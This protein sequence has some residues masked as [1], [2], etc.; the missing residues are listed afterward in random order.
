MNKLENKVAIITGGAMGNGLGIAK[1]FLKYGASIIILDYAE[2]IKSTI[3][4]L[5]DE[6]PNSKISGFQVDIRNHKLV[7]ACVEAIMEKYGKIDILVNN[8]GV[9][10]LESF[11]TMT[12][13]LRDF[14]FDIN[15]K[16]TWNITK[17]VVPYMKKNN[18]SS[19]INLSSVTGPLVA[20]SG[21]VAYA[22]TK[23]ALLGFTKSLAM[24]LVDN[25]IRVNAIMPGYIMTP[26]VEGISRDSNPENPGSVVEGIA[27]GIPMKR[28]GSIEELGELAAF[29]ASSE[30]SYITGQ[31]IV[32]DGGSTLPET[33][34]VGV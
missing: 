27:R 18:S 7:Q 9:C 15:I 10:R 22:T 21:E 31:G 25:N 8:A 30:S 12:D 34:S 5:R 4:S 1:V 3:K 33:M 16:G 17:S 23:A 19:I 14:H 13:E 2:K 24:E 29:L 20:D 26:M 32:I 28:L 6:F 11:E